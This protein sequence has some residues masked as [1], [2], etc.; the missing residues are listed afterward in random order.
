MQLIL[1]ARVAALTAA[2]SELRAN[3]AEI[4]VQCRRGDDGR[5]LWF[6]VLTK[7]PPPEAWEPPA[8]RRARFRLEPP[9]A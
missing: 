3:G 8:A 2:I 6:Y 4:D 7:A 5:A 9:V 1:D